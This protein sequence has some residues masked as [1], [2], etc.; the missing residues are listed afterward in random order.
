MAFLK[1][2]L[3]AVLFYYAIKLFW[4][5]LF[6]PGGRRTKDGEKGGGENYSELTDQKIDD[7]DFEDI[8]PGNKR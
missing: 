1:F 5:W 4:R 3:F 2:F 6:A 8:K 7:V